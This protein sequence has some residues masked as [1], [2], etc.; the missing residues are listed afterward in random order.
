MQSFSLCDSIFAE[1]P[2]P[3]ASQI[4]ASTLST[5]EDFHGVEM[6]INIIGITPDVQ[7][8]MDDFFN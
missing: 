2:S 6:I 1:S 7:K 3:L 5:I 4:L 8:S